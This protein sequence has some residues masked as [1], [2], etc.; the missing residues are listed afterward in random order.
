MSSDFAQSPLLKKGLLQQA[1][2]AL[3]TQFRSVIFDSD[4]RVQSIRFEVH[5]TPTASVPQLEIVGQLEF[6]G[7]SMKSSVHCA[8][9]IR[10][11]S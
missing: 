1:A 6:E 9:A 4:K 8:Q 5:E 7:I 3:Q 2:I 10:S 11:R